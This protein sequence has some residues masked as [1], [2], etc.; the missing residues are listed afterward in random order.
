MRKREGVLKERHMGY[1][2][3]ER[4]KKVKDRRGRHGKE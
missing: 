2:P 3:S 4:D 1:D